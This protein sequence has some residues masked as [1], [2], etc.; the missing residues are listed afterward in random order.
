MAGGQ[1][2]PLSRNSER[3]DCSALSPGTGNTAAREP[4]PGA[5]QPI[6][7]P[8]P[9]TPRWTS[10]QTRQFDWSLS[11]VDQ[12]VDN[13]ITRSWDTATQ[14]CIKWSASPPCPCLAQKAAVP[15]IID[16]DGS[17]P[18]GLPILICAALDPGERTR[19]VICSYNSVTA[20]FDQLSDGRNSGPLLPQNLQGRPIPDHGVEIRRQLL[21]RRQRTSRD[22]AS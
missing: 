19:C 8:Q 7:R 2:R 20:E 13:Y 3:L 16:P 11:A 22:Q 4:G 21:G 1:S 12:L 18:S 6:P 14:N 9:G 10:E 5:W 15:W 17:A